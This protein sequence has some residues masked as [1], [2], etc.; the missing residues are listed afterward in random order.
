ME[1]LSLSS[2]PPFIW[3]LFGSTEEDQHIETDFSATALVD[4]GIDRREQG[5][6]LRLFLNR[7]QSKK[8]ARCSP[9]CHFYGLQ[10]DVISDRGRNV[11]I[12]FDCGADQRKQSQI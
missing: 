12:S 1:S 4:S 5:E 10:R 2:F 8:A 7:S 9:R 3:F 6:G 11:R